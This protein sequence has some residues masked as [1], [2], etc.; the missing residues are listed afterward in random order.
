MKIILTVLISLIVL[1]GVCGTNTGCNTN[2][3]TE[4]EYKARI[5]REL[6]EIPV[7]ATGYKL[8]FREP[9]EN[10]P[11]DSI[12]YLDGSGKIHGNKQFAGHYYD[13]TV[14]NENGIKSESYKMDI[15]VD[16]GEKKIYRLIATKN[17]KIL[18]VYNRSFF[19]ITKF[20]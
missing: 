6:D 15:S 13:I 9:G 11:Y 5:K 1:T 7:E 20:S 19:I 12:M 2:K 17:I 3:E 16:D 10:P 18:A 4:A 8:A 14:Y